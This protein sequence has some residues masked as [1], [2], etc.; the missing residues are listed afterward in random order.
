[1]LAEAL[2]PVAALVALLV[3]A[4]VHPRGRVEATVGLAAAAATLAT[5]ILG[6]AEVRDTLEHLGPVVLFLVTILVVA[7]VCGRAG[8]FDAA[9]SRVRDAAR[10]RPVR[11]FTGVFLLAAVVT[12]VLSL[13]ATVVLLTP[14]VVGVAVSTSTSYRPGAHACLRMANSA[15]LLLPVS[16]LTNLLAMPHLDLTFAGFAL[17]MAPVLA[18]V[19]VVEYAALRVLFRRDLA[20]PPGTV[21]DP[22]HP[23]MPIVPLVAV[24]LMLTGFAVGS[25]FGVEPFWFSGAAAV[26]LAL[27]ARRRGLLGTSDVVAAAHPAFALFVL[28]LGVVVAALGTGFLGEWVADALPAGTGFADLLLVAV[29]AT[30]LANLLTNLS[31]TLL[32]VPL[33]GTLGDTAVL[34]ALLGLNIG[35][36]LSYTGSLANLLWR[37][38]MVRLGHPPPL[39][40]LHR[41]SLLIT[42]LSLISAVAVLSLVT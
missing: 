3:T 41:V 8:L 6:W 28:C 36:G 37:R 27:W 19:L 34:A 33:L 25:P 7:D 10:G 5:G 31:A 22:E 29:I 18:V 40:E 11:L 1:M 38:S 4:Y 15:S 13:D 39:R 16:N 26:A 35:S 9:A 21:E 20:M 42:P 14:V 12:T 2:V 17:T 32:L 24:G 30:V 23:P